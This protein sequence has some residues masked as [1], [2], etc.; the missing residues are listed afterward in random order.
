M[1]WGD[2]GYLPGAIYQGYL[3]GLFTGSN[4][5]VEEFDHLTKE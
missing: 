1:D 2:L 3:P 5:P 4:I